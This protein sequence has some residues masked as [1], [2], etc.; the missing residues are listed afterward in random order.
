M[1][2]KKLYFLVLDLKTTQNFNE[3]EGSSRE[4]VFETLDLI[5]AGE[6]VTIQEFIDQPPLEDNFTKMDKEWITNWAEDC[7][8][9]ETQEENS[10]YYE[11]Q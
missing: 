4:F 6:I 3:F 11:Y 1:K 8:L 10:R 5:K 9:R 2:T 7:I